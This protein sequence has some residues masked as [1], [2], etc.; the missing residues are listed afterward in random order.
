MTPGT[1]VRWVSGLQGTILGGPW[2]SSDHRTFYAVA[3]A[4]SQIPTIVPTELLHQQEEQ[5]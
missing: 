4:D 1:K 5:D 2:E 3:L